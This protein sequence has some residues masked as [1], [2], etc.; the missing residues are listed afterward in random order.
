MIGAGEASQ[1]RAGEASKIGAGESSKIL[2]YVH[3]ER[4][5]PAGVTHVKT[6]LFA[7]CVF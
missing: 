3:N 7:A 1:I 5:C 4:Q 2:K 6:M